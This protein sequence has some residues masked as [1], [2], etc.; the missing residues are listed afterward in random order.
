MKKYFLWVFVMTIGLHGVHAQVERVVG[1]WK[2]VDDNSGE[3]KSM[4][5]VYKMSDGTYQGKIEKLYL[6]PGAKCD[7]CEGADKGKPVTG[8]V[9]IRDMKADGDKLS[10]GYV[11]DPESGK[12]YY[13]SISIDEKTGKLKLRGSI[14]KFG[15]LGRTQY[16][17]RATN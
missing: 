11:L 16:W 5:R 12:K 15:V 17:I 8:M 14:D 13:G 9:I 4:V 7:K 3:I 6:H 1:Y 2:T 10:G